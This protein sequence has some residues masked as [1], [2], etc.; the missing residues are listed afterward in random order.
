MAYNKTVWK[1]R[2]GSGLNRFAKSQETGG[3]VVLENS[4]LSVAEPGTPFSAANMNHI[5]Q[6][7]ED[8][9]D[10][11]AA[12]VQERAEAD[13]VLQGAL[14][15]KADNNHAHENF[16][17]LM[18]PAEVELYTFAIDSDDALAAWASN[19]PGNDYSRVLVK[20]GTWTLDTELANGDYDD[21]A[22]AVDLSD[23][24]TKCVVGEVG[25]KIVINNNGSGVICGIKGNL[26]GIYRD[27]TVDVTAVAVGSGSASIGFYG[28][29]NLIHCSGWVYGVG[30]MYNRGYGFYGCA[31]LI[32]CFGYGEGGSR[33][34]AFGYT[35]CRTGLICKGTTH[36]CYMEQGSGETPWDD[37]AEGGYNLAE[38]LG[39]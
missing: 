19:A 18:M 35:Y 37:T 8:A 24:R 5:E 32:G 38:E 11:I 17:P 39:D 15:G 34:E 12:E 6:G 28:C 14:A 13:Q 33:G 31:N 30:S 26:A 22:A 16:P 2:Q 10:L 20:A 36:E 3:S 21:P 23:G 29:A 27:V 9:H 25:N 7:I 1:P 4:P